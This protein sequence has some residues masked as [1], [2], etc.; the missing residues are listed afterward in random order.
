MTTATHT[1]AENA[2]FLSALAGTLERMG[3]QDKN[4]ARLHELA[5]REAEQDPEYV[6]YVNSRVRAALGCPGP[7]HTLEEARAI[8]KSWRAG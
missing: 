8:V 1:H 4:I 3:D 6:A 7:D 2:A 5:A